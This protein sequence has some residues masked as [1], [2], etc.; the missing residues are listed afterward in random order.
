[1]NETFELPPH[2][3]S[4]PTKETKS[5]QEPS[6]GFEIDEINDKTRLTSMTI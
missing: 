5:I 4:S 6:I 2:E 1:L 3:L